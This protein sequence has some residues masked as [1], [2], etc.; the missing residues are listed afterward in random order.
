MTWSPVAWLQLKATGLDQRTP[1]LASIVQEIINQSGWATGNSLVMIITGTGQR[2]AEA[3]EADHAGAPLLHIEY[4]LPATSTQLT[5]TQLLLTAPLTGGSPIASQTSPAIS[6]S[7][8]AINVPTETPTISFTETP[9]PTADVPTQT[10][11]STP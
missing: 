7:P 4:S 8:T 6:A 1:N 2:V 9:F 11:T 10:P 3:Y 5:S